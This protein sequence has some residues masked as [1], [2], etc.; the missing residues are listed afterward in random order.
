MTFLEIYGIGALAILGLMTT[1]WIISLILKDASIVDIFWGP[2]FVMT[3]WIYFALTPNGFTL[4]KRVI[5]ALVTIWGLR[6]GAIS[7]TATW[8]RARIFAIR[9]GVG[10]RGTPGGGAVFSRSF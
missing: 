1:L 10:R 9:S 8:A 2:G 5:S 6:L 4:R 3:C 7:S